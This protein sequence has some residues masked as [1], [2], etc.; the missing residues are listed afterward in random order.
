MGLVAREAETSASEVVWEVVDWSDAAISE[1]VLAPSRSRGFLFAGGSVAGEE[2]GQ[3]VGD[4]V[5]ASEF[6]VGADHF[7][8][9]VAAFTVAI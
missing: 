2:V 3:G 6:F 7:G 8:R 9:G 4:A 1:E 5:Y